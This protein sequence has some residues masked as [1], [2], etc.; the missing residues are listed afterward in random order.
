MPGMGVTMNTLT[1]MRCVPAM[2]LMIVLSMVVV[3]HV[4]TSHVGCIVA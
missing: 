2:R 4:D 1:R 3:R